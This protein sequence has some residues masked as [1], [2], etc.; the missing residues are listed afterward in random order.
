MPSP[1]QLL[2]DLTSTP[3]DASGSPSSSA[4][5]SPSGRRRLSSPL[6]LRRKIQVGSPSPPPPPSPSPSPRPH[7]RST[8]GKLTPTL[9]R[10]LTAQPSLRTRGFYRRVR[11][12]TSGKPCLLGERTLPRA[13]LWLGEL[14]ILTLHSPG[15]ARQG[16]HRDAVCRKRARYGTSRPARPERLWPRLAA[17]GCRPGQ[18]LAPAKPA[19]RHSVRVLCA[20]FPTQATLCRENG[21]TEQ[22][23]GC[24]QHLPATPRSAAREKHVVVL[25]DVSEDGVVTVNI[26]GLF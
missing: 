6:D 14:I 2:V 4:A 10:L 19:P 25:S 15:G 9:S 11:P 8:A 5:A 16:G 13:S 24:P 12:S 22:V 20:S 18:T 7:K 23:G 3:R 21:S 1:K 17:P 26:S